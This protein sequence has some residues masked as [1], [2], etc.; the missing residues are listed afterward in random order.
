M[1]MEKR[2]MHYA[3]IKLNGFYAFR[4]EGENPLSGKREQQ[5]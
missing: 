3:N 2:T 1:A 5:Q 4:G